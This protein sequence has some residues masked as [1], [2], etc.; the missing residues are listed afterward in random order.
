M[1][2]ISVI[3]ISISLIYSLFLNFFFFSK[4]HI[5]TYENRIFSVLVLINFLGLLLE[6]LCYYTV[7][8]FGIN[9][10]Y[11]IIIN[12]MF[13][14]YLLLFAFVFFIYLLFVCFMNVEQLNENQ[15]LKK[16][17][18]FIFSFFGICVVLI[19]ILPVKIKVIRNY[20]YSYGPA[21]NVVYIAS[22]ILGIICTISLIINIKNII[23]KRYLLIF[24]Y[25]IGL[26]S[27]AIIQ[28]IYPQLTLAT[29]METFII[30]LM[31]NTIENPDV[32]MIEQLE[33]AKDQAEKANMAKSDFLSSMSHEI[34]TPLNAIV[35]LSTSLTEE[36]P[37][38]PPQAIEDAK[39]ILN[40]SETLLEI[41]GNILDINKIES[42]KMEIVETP[43]NFKEEITNMVK[44]TS[45][46]IG[47]KPIDFTLDIAPDI[48]YELLG[49]KVHVKE[50]IN[51]LLSNAI[52]YT[53]KGEV[54][55]SIKCIN[56]NDLCNL[57]I[58]VKDT[59]RG[60]K[61]ESINKLFTKFERL[62][63]ERNT[64]T[65]GTGLGLAIT[66]KL[67][68]MM[69]G[70]INVQSTYG[71]GSLF[72]AN[73]PQKISI[74]SAPLQ[75]SSPSKEDLTPSYSTKKILIVDDN[76]LNIKVAKR[77]LNQFNLKIEEASSGKE[78]IEKVKNTNDYDL[79]L[80]D[81]MM[82]EMSGE[83]TLKKLKEDSR[84]TTPVVAL[85]ADALVGA[86]EK[87]LAS[88]FV[89]YIP[90]PFTKEQIKEILDNEFTIQ[91][92]YNPS[93]DR[94]KDVEPVIIGNDENA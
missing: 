35:G 34:R 38:L 2:S 50:I 42:D 43:Y 24:A 18:N 61:A 68:E 41:V 85:T 58:S 76:A 5:K 53:E 79:I 15:T 93:A 73:I 9:Q 19:I 1:N 67:I 69:G 30:F 81:I 3:L 88:G 10:I 13:L 39:D 57:I 80:M 92:K 77:V 32:K 4:K 63:V 91:K 37:D 86:K 17:R 74:M 66:K 72:V 27:I 21:P 49:D 75:T 11:T 87:Y 70:K 59:G 48:P 51:N 25:L 89:G 82:P 47:E 29:S 55:L 52:K 14:I 26:S 94:F 45:T 65:E 22:L 20:S 36:Y 56:N 23:R 44:V 54:K 8:S 78:C 28:K 12:K 84:F 83:T 7:V 40:A 46:R 60:I 6:L 71:S 31:Y 16:I 64:T 33:T 90:K 62:G